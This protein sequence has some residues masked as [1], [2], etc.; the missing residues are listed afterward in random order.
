MKWKNN[1]L[2]P[3]FLRDKFLWVEINASRMTLGIR[4]ESGAM[5]YCILNQN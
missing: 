5:K 1:E 2:L 4:M 3:Y